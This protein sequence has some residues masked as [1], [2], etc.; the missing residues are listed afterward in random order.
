MNVV[1]NR[2]EAR[3]LPSRYR[4]A[5]FRLAAFLRMQRAR[6]EHEDVVLA[7]QPYQSTTEVL[8]IGIWFFGTVSCYLAWFFEDWPL[9]LAAAFAFALAVVLFQ[10]VFISFGVAIA[11]FL[12]KLTGSPVQNNAELNGAFCLLLLGVA[13]LWFV[14]DASWLRVVA[15]LY[16][17]CLAMN[18]S[19]AVLLRLLRR[20]VD[21]MEAS[22]G[23]ATSGA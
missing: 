12:R 3:D 19:A 10:V 1:R 11:P 8:A 22:Y 7:V 16:F 23:G 21:A 20:R 4:F 13:S 14:R 15:W 9:P 6:A 5:I 17:L 2:A 18:G